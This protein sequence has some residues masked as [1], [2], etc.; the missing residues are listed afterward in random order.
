MQG[1]IAPASEL[2]LTQAVLVD[3]RLQETLYLLLEANHA[4]DRAGDRGGERGHA[5]GFL[6][7]GAGGILAL[8]AGIVIAVLVIRIVTRTE[9]RLEREKELA[10]V[11]LHS[12]VDGVITT[13][14]AG[15]IEYL[16]PVAEQYLGWTSA[17][18]RGQAARP[19]ST[20]CVDERSGKPIE[21]LPLTDAQRRRR[22]QS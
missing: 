10:E 16:N 9:A 14:A 18:A 2:N 20:A 1:E 12:I 22:T 19:R 4:A 3:S 17:E 15:R 21:T 6:L 13:D 7:I 8:L 11:T 5:H